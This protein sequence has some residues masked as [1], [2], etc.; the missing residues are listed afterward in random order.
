MA[1]SLPRI[2]TGLNVNRLKNTLKSFR[3]SD[4][5]SLDG[6]VSV[7]L[8]SKV[9]KEEMMAAQKKK[10]QSMKKILNPEQYEKWLK[11]DK[12]KDKPKDGKIKANQ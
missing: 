10:E 8:P 7:T 2:T 1:V 3:A 11:L 6:S 4:S 5:L 9:S 12:K